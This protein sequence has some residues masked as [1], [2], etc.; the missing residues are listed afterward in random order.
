[1]NIRNTEA[2][3]RVLVNDPSL[4]ADGE[5]EL[6]PAEPP[7][8]DLVE[9]NLKDSLTD[10]LEHRPEILQAA[11]N[12]RAASVRLG[13]SEKELLPV[14]DLVTEAYVSG[15]KGSFDI[16]GAYGD[17]FSEGQPSFSVGLVLEVP[18]HNRAAK[19][20]H[21]QRRLE[22]QQLTYQLQQTTDTLRAEV[23]VAVRIVE[24]AF[25]EM[26][27]KYRSM[28]AADAEV[29]Y[30]GDRWRVLP[31]EDQVASFLLED[32]LDAQE[33]QATQAADFVT[34]Q[35]SYTVALAELKRATGTLLQAESISTTRVCADGLPQMILD[36]QPAT[37]PRN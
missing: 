4:I 26:H 37:T 29:R 5:I 30:L 27:S 17:Q 8:R 11:K 20:R 15:L 32:L 21:Q 10:A 34:A 24:T 35:V 25:R 33:R 31:G 23:E 3:L 14:L 1:M 9:I 36:K 7:A 19:A 22:L 2:R 16:A 28:T 12:V 6:V 13:I 18:L